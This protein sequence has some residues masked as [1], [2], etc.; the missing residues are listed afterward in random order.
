MQSLNEM[1]KL[2][3]VKYGVGGRE[4]LP[5]DLQKEVRGLDE[6]IE[7]DMQGNDYYEYYR[8]SEGIDLDVTWNHG[9]WI[10]KQQNFL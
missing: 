2:V 6:M 4:S 3:I 10:L 8:I 7:L 9:E 5:S 1:A